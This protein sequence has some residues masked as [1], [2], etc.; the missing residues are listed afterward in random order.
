VAARV[1]HASPAWFEMVGKQMVEA[2]LDA[3]L[4]A[5][6]NVSLLERFTDDADLGLRFEIVGGVPSFRAGV[7]ADETADIV[8]HVTTAASRRLNTVYEGDPAYRVAFDEALQHGA[9]RIEGD[10]GKLGAWFAGVH[11]AIVERTV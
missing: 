1:E 9:L 2:A 10:V 11:D 6:V 8:I 5:D 7:G 3:G 4:G